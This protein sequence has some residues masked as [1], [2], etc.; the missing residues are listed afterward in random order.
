MDNI[1]EIVPS[2][3]GMDKINING[4]LMVKDKCRNNAFYWYCENRDEMGC[5]GRAVTR[6]IN[7]QHYLKSAS[8]HIH[9]A[10][11]SRAEV[12]KTIARIKEHARLTN[13]KPTQLLQT[14][15]TNSPHYVYQ[16]LPSSNAI[17][18]TV[19]RI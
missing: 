1:C 7:N 5:T 3:R 19:Q 18:Q 15:I 12:V 2:I 13:K 16:Y 14:A 17:R 10:Q 9:A 6:L 11:A 4:F 8:N